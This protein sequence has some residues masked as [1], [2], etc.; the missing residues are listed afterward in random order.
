LVV[1]VVGG[2]IGTAAVL[3][4]LLVVVNR[5]DWWRGYVAAT[6][7]VVLAAGASLVPLAW[8]LRRGGPAVVQ[9]FMASSALR[10]AVA[11]GVAALAVGVGRYPTLPTFVLV[12][13]YY[14]VL[15]AVETACLARSVKPGNN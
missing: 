9:T 11:L 15:L 1:A 5:A 10:G 14:L 13:P 2:V 7:A 8:G 4:A 6:V 12:M 3:A